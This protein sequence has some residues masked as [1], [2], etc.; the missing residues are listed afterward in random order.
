MAAIT[1]N[2]VIIGEFKVKSMFGSVITI[3]VVDESLE[4]QWSIIV[5]PLLLF[6]ASSNHILSGWYQENLKFQASFEILHPF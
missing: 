6:F 5:C 2:L 3:L 1:A 4:L